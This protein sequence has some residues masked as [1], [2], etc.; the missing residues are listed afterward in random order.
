MAITFKS[1]VYFAATWNPKKPVRQY[2]IDAYAPL[3]KEGGRGGQRQA[4]H[5]VL[6]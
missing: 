4:L 2:S 1:D 3:Q 6:L 5:R